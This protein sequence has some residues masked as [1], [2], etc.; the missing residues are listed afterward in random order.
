M[1][2]EYKGI[3]FYAQEYAGAH[4]SK[5]K[6]EGYHLYGFLLLQENGLYTYRVRYKGYQANT[7]A[8]IDSE[9]AQ[10]ESACRVCCSKLNRR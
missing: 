4:I 10:V 5:Y 2:V 6:Y 8:N 1:V 7:G 3:R 9:W